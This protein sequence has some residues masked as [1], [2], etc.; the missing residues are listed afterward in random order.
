MSF[1]LGARGRDAV[2]CSMLSAVLAGS[3]AGQSAFE[4]VVMAVVKGGGGAN[5]NRHCEVRKSGGNKTHVLPTL[6]HPPAH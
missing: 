1:Q 4:G 6:Y 3:S 5:D 2:L